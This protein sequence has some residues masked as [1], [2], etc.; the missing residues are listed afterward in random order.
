M[1]KPIKLQSI[2]N[3]NDFINKSKTFKFISK[4]NENAQNE[5]DN[6]LHKNSKSTKNEEKDKK[7][8]S[9]Q[10]IKRN[11]KLAELKGS[12]SVDIKYNKIN[13]NHNISKLNYKPIK[14]ND[15]E[16]IDNKLNVNIFS[17]KSKNPAKKNIYVT[18]IKK[19]KNNSMDKSHCIQPK[20]LFHNNTILPLIQNK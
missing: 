1:K 17:T 8:S 7:I 3:T 5:L 16:D 11:S 6:F 12:L 9:C 2:K 10:R 4:N 18:S 13:E 20:K 15:Y 14:L 19:T